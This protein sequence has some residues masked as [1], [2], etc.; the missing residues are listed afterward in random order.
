MMT[1][2]LGQ[3]VNL[4]QEAKNELKTGGTT[5]SFRARND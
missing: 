1:M 3:D 5:Q 2:N 4:G